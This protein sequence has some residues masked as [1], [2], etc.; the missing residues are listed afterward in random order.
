[1][2]GPE[3]STAYSCLVDNFPN[4]E[5][6]M[7]NHLEEFH[8]FMILEVI[9]G[10]KGKLKQLNCNLD[11]FESP[12]GLPDPNR[13]RIFR[14]LYNLLQMEGVGSLEVEVYFNSVKLDLLEFKFEDYEFGETPI[15]CHHHN[16]TSND[17]PQLPCRTVTRVDYLQLLGETFDPQ[18]DSPGRKLLDAVDGIPFDLK[19]F[20][21][22][23]P[24]IRVVDLDNWDGLVGQIKEGAFI[25]FLAQCTALTKLRMFGCKF[26]AALYCALAD[27]ES[28]AT[29]DHLSLYEANEYNVPINVLLLGSLSYLRHLQTNLATVRVMLQQISKMKIESEMLFGFWSPLDRSHRYH[30]LVQ[31]LDAA[32]E[33][34]LHL[35][36]ERRDF[37]DKNGT[38]LYEGRL[39][40]AELENY[41]NSEENAPITYHWLDEQYNRSVT[42]MD[43][44]D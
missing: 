19:A 41:F 2:F 29:L 24:C 13:L 18:P 37:N 16:V 38:T 30:C 1:M 15:K 35:L 23:Y 39:S 42:Q 14:N 12:T 40:F 22:V 9:L 6:M 34:R 10:S 8:L 4:L 25:R 36:V 3:P 33:N 28:L 44:L 31:K 17:L 27:L 26:S 21:R 43:E 32:D 7:W 5:I 11:R 20:A